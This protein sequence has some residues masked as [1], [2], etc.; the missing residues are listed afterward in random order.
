MC[1]IHQHQC[2]TCAAQFGHG[3]QAALGELLQQVLRQPWAALHDGVG[4]VGV[5]ATERAKNVLHI[6][7]DVAVFVDGLQQGVTHM[8]HIGR[9]IIQRGKACAINE[10]AGIAQFMQLGMG[11]PGLLNDFC[12]LVQPCRKHHGQHVYACGLQAAGQ[13]QTGDARS[14]RGGIHHQPCAFAEAGAQP[15]QH[16]VSHGIRT[17]LQRSCAVFHGIQRHPA[18]A[19]LGGLTGFCADK[20]LRHLHLGVPC[21]HGTAGRRPHGNAARRDLRQ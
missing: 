7:I 18:L 1:S 11:M 8:L 3:H 9:G 14:T 2:G 15:G 4:H 19:L 12:P 16:L 5:A 13:R 20:A 10:H 21:A 6:H 17:V